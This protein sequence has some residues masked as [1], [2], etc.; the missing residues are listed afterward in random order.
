MYELH[1]PHHSVEYMNRVIRKCGPFEKVDIIHGRLSLLHFSFKLD[2]S[3]YCDDLFKINDLRM[4]VDRLDILCDEF[5]TMREI[6]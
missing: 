2:L 6:E 3:H 5:D 1:A 4:I